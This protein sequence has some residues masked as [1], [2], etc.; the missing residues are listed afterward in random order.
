M[1]RT[2]LYAVVGLVL[3]SILSAVGF[4]GYTYAQTPEAIRQPSFEHYHFRTQLVVN[5]EAVNFAEDK[6][7]QSYDVGACSD[8]VAPEPFHFH[9]GMDQMTHI[10]W[11]G[12]TGGL[13]LKNY[14]WN[15]IGGS[16][17]SLGRHY[18]NG[19]MMPTGTA[20]VYG[21][22]LPELPDDANFYV[23]IGDEGGYE[24]KAWEDF[25][26]QDLEAFFGV[27]SLLSQDEQSSLPDWLIPPAY[28]HSSE[29]DGHSSDDSDELSEAELTRINNLIGNVVI[30]AQEDEPTDEQV[31][32][33]FN[34]LVPLQDSACGG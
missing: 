12:M 25:L 11:D 2:I 9:D 22:V 7:Q 26:N 23:Y 30:F 19:N 20:S 24:Q 33:R 4:F 21:D 8:E 31:R 29:D 6:Y 3:V 27:Q 5:G 28:A 10:H 15:L 18:G 13:L 16:D 32:E 34:N 14:G 1:N 17:G